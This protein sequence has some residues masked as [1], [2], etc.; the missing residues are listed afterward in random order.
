MSE[1][2]LILMWTAVLWFVLFGLFATSGK[3]PQYDKDEGY[4]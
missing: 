4:E 2:A 1:I 3:P